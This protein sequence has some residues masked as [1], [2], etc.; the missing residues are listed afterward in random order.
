MRPLSVFLFALFDAV[1][2]FGPL[3]EAVSRFLA[4]RVKDLPEDISG[5]DPSCFLLVSFFFAPNLKGPTLQN[6]TPARKPSPPLPNKHKNFTLLFDGNPL[7]K[8]SLTIPYF[9]ASASKA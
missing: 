8:L 5:T 6:P 3:V 4:R 2:T 1:L 7:L 9:L